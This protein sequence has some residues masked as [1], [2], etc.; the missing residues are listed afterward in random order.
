LTFECCYSDLIKLVK[1]RTKDGAK[2]D[3]LKQWNGRFTSKRKDALIEIKPAQFTITN[4]TT[5]ERQ[6]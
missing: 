3:P 1:V 5:Q 4:E 2:F 6:E